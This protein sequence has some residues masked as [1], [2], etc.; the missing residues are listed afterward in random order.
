MSTVTPIAPDGRGL[1]PGVTYNFSQGLI[2]YR[3]VPVPVQSYEGVLAVVQAIDSRRAVSYQDYNRDTGAVTRFFDPR[4]NNRGTSPANSDTVVSLALPTNPASGVEG[5]PTNF[6]LPPTTFDE[7]G[8]PIAQITPIAPPQTV[9]APLAPTQPQPAP[10]P[11]SDDNLAFEPAPPPSVPS[12]QA[13]GNITG[14]GELDDEPSD[15]LIAARNE[16]TTLGGQY[17]LRFDPNNT[18]DGPYYIVNLQRGEIVAGG[19]QTETSA[20]TDLNLFN[21]PDPAVDPFEG[22]GAAQEAERQRSLSE[23][24]QQAALAD[25]EE[26]GAARVAATLGEARAQ[27]AISEQQKAINQGDWR[28]RLRLADSADYLY[29]DPN[30]NDLYLLYP[31]HVSGGVVFPYTPRIQTAYRASYEQYDLTHSNYRGYF[32]KNSAVDPIMI[33]ARFTAQDTFEANYV[34]AVIHFFRSVTKMFYG[35]DPAYRGSPPPL[36]FLDGLGE[37][38]F[39]RHPCVVSSFAYNLPDDVDYIRAGSGN[40]AGLQDLLFRRDRTSVPTNSFSSALERLRNAGLSQGAQ[41]EQSIPPSE[42]V[43]LG[44]DQPTY[45]PTQ[46]D[47]E[48][49]LLPMQ[50]REQVS[51]EFSLK[52]FA[53][54]TLLGKGFW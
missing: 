12:P 2:T 52:D 19:Y 13:Q 1:P 8:T 5:N 9:A 48:L 32:Y 7:F 38:Q 44:T 24:Q 3:G 40:N 28:V 30:I 34:L 43:V 39:N 18:T 27:K 29:Q 20:R 11:V 35:Q 15:R 31:L 42:S 51:K 54:G 36:V 53:S 10:V 50:S 45:V 41:P 26:S 16:S 6:V 37:Y 47:I 23:A 22:A 14:Y 4:T 33:S 17:E 49:E 25:L 46:I 21:Q